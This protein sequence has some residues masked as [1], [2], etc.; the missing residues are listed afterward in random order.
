[1]SSE[2]FHAGERAAQIRAGVQDGLEQRAAQFIRPYMPRQ[3]REF[4][5]QLPFLVMAARDD[6]QR[7]WITLLAGEPGFIHPVSET[8]LR[9]GA[10]LPAGNPLAAAVRTNTEVGLLGI[11]LDSRR[12]NRVNGTLRAGAE[13][14]M[15]F[16][17][18]QSFGNCPQYITERQWT[19]APEDQPVPSTHPSSALS[20]EQGQWIAQADTFFIGSGFRASTDSAASGMDASHR[21]GP[22]GFA[23]VRDENTLVFPDY[24]GNNHF[25]TIGNLLEDPRVALLFVDF[26]HG[27]LLHLTGTATVDWNSDALLE[28]QDAKRLIT[29]RIHE[30]VE[31]R[32]ALPIRWTSPGSEPLTLRVVGRTKESDRITSFLLQ[33]ADGQALPSFK[34]GQHLPITAPGE[35][36]LRRTYSLSNAPEQQS[37]RISVKREPR[38]LVSVQLHDALQLGDELSAGTP[39]GDFVLQ[40]TERTA[41]LISA[42]VGITPMLSML[43]H[44]VA[45]DSRRPTVFLHGARDGQQ[46]AFA[47]EVQQ[48]AA[49]RSWIR[50]AQLLSQPGPADRLGETYDAQGH[51]SAEHI[52]RLHPTLDGEFYLCGPTAM[53]AE[54][55][56]G[57]EARGVPADRIHFETFGPTGG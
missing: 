26:E 6:A 29:V 53:L 10:T 55:T 51:I 23:E 21:G 16:E 48:L 14:E 2:V 20:A 44:L 49:G 37:Y 42:G 40:D 8:G 39:A 17:T 33:P 22:V 50:T 27:H 47:Q 52:A 12:R 11:E 57:L 25:N 15:H 46:R 41:V 35:P 1:M 30:V 38:G 36:A 3:H 9:L 34:P 31:Q 18:A 43:Q 54:V 13:G 19:A 7:P 24:A 45:S 32:N 28:R 5:Q 4:Y 56:A